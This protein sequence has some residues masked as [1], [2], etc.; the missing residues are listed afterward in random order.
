MDLFLPQNGSQNATKP[1]FRKRKS[2]SNESS[3]PSKRSRDKADS[4][5]VDYPSDV[6]DSSIRL[7]D[8]IKHES[9]KG[10][11]RGVISHLKVTKK[12][13]TRHANLLLTERNG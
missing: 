11:K 2:Q 7:D 4:S 3:S 13:L 10:S 5:H 1:N 12:E 6:I 8:E 9:V